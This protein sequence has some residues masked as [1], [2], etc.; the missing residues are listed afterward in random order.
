VCFDAIFLLLFVLSLSCI[1]KKKEEF[2]HDNG[3]LI[4]DTDDILWLRD[5]SGTGNPHGDVCI[6]FAFTLCIHSPLYSF[7]YTLTR[8]LFPFSSAELDA[9]LG[10][11]SQERSVESRAKD[12]QTEIIGDTKLFTMNSPTIGTVDGV[13]GRFKVCRPAILCAA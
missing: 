4:L 5:S 11:K 9:L 8:L 3:I 13:R 10:I 2:T 1:E 6:T 7:L 12:L